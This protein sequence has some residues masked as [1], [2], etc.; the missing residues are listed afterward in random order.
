MAGRWGLSISY[1]SAFNSLLNNALHACWQI[2][3]IF[4]ALIE[5]LHILFSTKDSLY[6]FSGALS[7]RSINWSSFGVM[8]I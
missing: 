3:Y 6:S 8:I 4:F 5:F 1:L 7:I 2:W